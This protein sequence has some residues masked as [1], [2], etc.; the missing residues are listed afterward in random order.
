MARQGTF[1]AT[2]TYDGKRYYSYGK[3]QDEADRNAIKKRTLLEVGAIEKKSR[4]T[5][6]EWAYKWLGDYKDGAV[7]D[8]WYK[9]T[10][11]I[12]QNHILDSIGDKLIK[13]VTAADIHR[14]MNSKRH[15]SESH[16]RKIAQILLQIL[17]SAEENGIIVKVPIRRIKVASGRSGT[18]SRTITDEERSLTLI[19]A[20]KYPDEGLFFLIMLFCGLRPQEVARLQMGDYDKKDRI[21]RVRRARKADG[22]VG[23]PK[24]NSGNRDIPVPDYLAERLDKLNKK[25]N[26]PIVTSYQ[27]RPLTKT[28]QKRLWHKFKRK[29]DIE[30]GA[31]LYRHSVTQT[32]LA[33]DLHPYCYRH[34]YCTDLQDAGVPITVAQRLMG[35]SD[36]KVTAQIYTHHS[37]RSFDDAREKINNLHSNRRGRPL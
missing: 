4:V 31:K 34:T 6:S 15:F 37:A 8:A 26:E 14:L 9:Q 2:F 32:T 36:I 17:S 21:I 22:T 19:T 13:N 35:H 24:S 30:N 33:D 20:D 16:Q 3:S 23:E 18:A 25:S 1:T 11:G 5:V 7:S 12:M 10:K 27:G 28:S 29:M